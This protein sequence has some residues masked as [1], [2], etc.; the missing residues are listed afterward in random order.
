MA[1]LYN[2]SRS[3]SLRIVR[4]HASCLGRYERGVIPGTRILICIR[5]ALAD[6]RQGVPDKVGTR[7]VLCQI[8]NVQVGIEHQHG[9]RD[10]VYNTG[11]TEDG[12]RVAFVE[13]C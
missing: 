7:H 13:A 8:G 9:A 4:P 12:V 11:G 3:R 6:C 2:G 10:G 1:G 5:H